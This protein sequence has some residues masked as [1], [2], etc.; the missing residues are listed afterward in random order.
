MQPGAGMRG[1]VRALT[2]TTLPWQHMGDD[3]SY[4]AAPPQ[5]GP[6]APGVERN[7]ACA[8]MTCTHKGKGLSS[9]QQKGGRL[10]T[11][12]SAR[13][14]VQ[15]RSQQCR[16]NTLTQAHTHTLPAPHASPR[17]S[18]MPTVNREC[19]GRHKQPRGPLR[20]HPADAPRPHCHGSTVDAL[21]CRAGL[22]S[23]LEHCPALRAR[24][25]CRCSICV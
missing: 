5:H 10:G 14:S 12:G 15:E 4:V 19:S 11:K 25:W 24:L 16:V 6:L 23:S 18:C 9:H 1:G 22:S 8:G 13:A 17:R 21:C 2:A 3:R 7:A 20:M